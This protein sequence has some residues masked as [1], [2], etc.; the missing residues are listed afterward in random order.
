MLTYASRRGRWVVA[1]TILGSGMAMLDGTVVGLALPA[2]GREFDTGFAA[3]QWVFNGYTLTLAGF[4]LLGGALGDRF[5][6]R[7]MFLVGT[8]GFALASALCGVAWSAPVLVTARAL[9]GVAAALLT[10]GS[11]AILQASFVEQDRSRAIGAWTGLTGVAA[12]V[13]PFVGG[14]LIAR[15]SWRTVFYI[16]VPVAILL[17]PITLHY[18][19][20]SKAPARSRR[21]DAGGAVLAALGLAGLT[22]GLIEGPARAW[23]GASTLAPLGGGVAALVALVLAERRHPDPLLPLGLFRSRQFSGA[24]A[25]TFLVYGA[26]GGALFLLPVVL[27]NAASYSP[28][29][30]GLALLPLTLLML[31]LSGPSGALA[32]RIG[33]RLQMTVGPLVI[34]AGLGLLA[35]FAGPGPYATR[36]LPGM[37]VFG[38]GLAITVAPLT[39]TVLGAAPTEHA[40]IASAVNNDVARAAGLFAVALLPPL[41][42]VTG[43]SYRDPSKLAAGFHQAAWLAAAACALGAAMALAT[44]RNPRGPA[45]GG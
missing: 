3:L 36:V 44:I 33:P 22:W 14:A 21:L 39:A 5:G 1:A 30:A 18:V 19:P 15:W 10:P 38:L 9:Q 17:V 41:A 27:Q 40:G 28:I 35:L 8:V 7:R 37:L 20:E 12:A 34:G 23:A 6:R 45:G 31:A 11:L 42:G 32:G 13:G 26:L 24:N 25:V 16:N 2:I 43:M 29:E 4:L